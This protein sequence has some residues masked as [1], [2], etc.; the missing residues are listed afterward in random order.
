MPTEGRELHN[1]GLS[2]DTLAV[3]RDGG[4]NGNKIRKNSIEIS[5]HQKT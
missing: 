1:K 5:K 3:L 2:E 4:T